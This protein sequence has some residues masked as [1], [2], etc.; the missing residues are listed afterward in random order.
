[1]LHGQREH[2]G[3]VRVQADV[4]AAKI[5][6][7]L[8]RNVLDHSAARQGAVA[9][10]VGGAVKPDDSR[11]ERCGQMQRAGVAGDNQTRLSQK[12]GEPGNG[13]LDDGRIRR[14][15]GG[16]D[17]AAEIFF[18]GS[19]IDDRAETVA[20]KKQAA[21]RAKAVRRPTLRFPAAAGTD[22]DVIAGNAFARKRLADKAQCIFRD[23]QRKARLGLRLRSGAHGEVHGH[24]H[25]VAAGGNHAVGIK[26]SG[27]GFAR[28]LAVAADAARRAGKPGEHGRAVA[29]LK[30]E[31]AGVASAAQAANAGEN[32]GK[33]A[34]ERNR[35]VD[36]RD[37]FDQGRPA[38]IY[39]PVDCGGGKTC[40]QGRDGRNG[41]NQVTQRAE[42]DDEKSLRSIRH[43][44]ASHARGIFGLRLLGGTNG[45][46]EVLHGRGQAMAQQGQALVAA[47]VHPVEL[48]HAALAFE[49]QMAVPGAVGTQKGDERAVG[50]R[51]FDGHIVDV[52]TR[53]KETEAAAGIVPRG[54]QVEQHGD[55]FAG[56]IVVDLAVVRAATAAHRDGGGAAGEVHAK[57]FL[58][59]FAKF[60]GLQRVNHGLEAGAEFYGIQ[61]EAARLRDA[62][63]IGIDAAERLGLHEIAEDKV[64]VGRAFKRRCVKSFEIEDLV[65]HG[66]YCRPYLS[67]RR[68]SSE[69]PIRGLYLGLEELSESTS[70]IAQDANPAPA[71]K[72]RKN[73]NLRRRRLVGVVLP[74]SLDAEISGAAVAGSGS[75]T[76]R[77]DFPSGMV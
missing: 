6:G 76:T 50:R 66:R 43:A 15:C 17:F 77:K 35:C 44:G 38:L 30:V 24:V 36:D 71:P 11:A 69:V 3:G 39:D 61:R 37:H 49:G 16:H 46:E 53:T 48:D 29:S 32:I 75:I 33:R 47:V 51:N 13:E 23:S 26:D 68:M 57:F 8:G 54:I 59:G 31:R 64:L 18:A 34:A 10:G 60:R 7:R 12:R 72:S 58:E 45:A 56:G 27:A 21:E 5:I 9:L 40:A 4:I 2:G 20:L 28:G 19:D 14:T 62:G 25:D 73:A 67:A 42:A 65:S 22:D 63:I 55:N 1:M 41:V 70:Q 52:F 74:L